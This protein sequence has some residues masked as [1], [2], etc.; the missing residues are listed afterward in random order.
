MNFKKIIVR[1]VV[2]ILVVA[3]LALVPAYF[4]T[5]K[6]NETLNFLINSPL[7]MLATQ[8][9]QADPQKIWPLIQNHKNPP[10]FRDDF[11]GPDL[12]PIWDFIN[13]NGKGIVT[14]P[15]VV[16]AANAEII[17]GKMVL[18]VMHDPDFDNEDPKW[19]PGQAAAERYNNAYV[20]GF[21]GYSPTPTEDIVIETRYAV[22]QDFHGSTGIWFEEQDTFDPNTGVMTKPFRSFGVSYLGPQSKTPFNGNQLEAVV[23]FVPVCTRRID[24]HL[25]VT[26]YN[27][28]KM[29][30]SLVDEKKMKVDLFINDQFVQNCVFPSFYA[31]EIQLW[32]DNYRITDLDIGHLNVPEGVVDQTKFD[33]VSVTVVKK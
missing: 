30:W 26:Q 2:F 27:T 1:L 3:V 19:H 20:I 12:N 14:H 13:L 28:Y 9:K 15:P 16:H 18:S 23:G 4:W 25:D 8:G 10:S 17:D 29:V 33:Y 5:F 6:H 7:T 11:N 21:H 32:A 22:T 31:G 24:N